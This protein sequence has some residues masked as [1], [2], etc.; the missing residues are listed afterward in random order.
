[1]SWQYLPVSAWQKPFLIIKSMKKGLLTSF[2]VIHVALPIIILALP[3]T[4]R[5]IKNSLKKW[6][7]Y[8]IMLPAS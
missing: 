4:T 1:M 6:C 5:T 2:K 3:P 8:Y 7:T